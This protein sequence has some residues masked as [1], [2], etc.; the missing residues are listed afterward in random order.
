MK[1]T[2]NFYLSEWAVSDLFPDLAKE[3]TFTD[4][5]EIRAMLSAKN[6][7]STRDFANMIMA[8]EGYT[9]EFKI[10]RGKSIP[11]L[12]KALR[13][14]GYKVSKTS[15][16]LDCEATDFI[17]IIKSRSHIIQLSKAKM[18]SL[19]WKIFNYLIAHD[20]YWQLII[21]EDK[22]N[23]IEFIHH[24]I[25]PYNHLVFNTKLKKAMFRQNGKYEIIKG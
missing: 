25:E 23:N 19:Y 20:R 1:L 24:S 10:T 4:A 5:D 3:I 2:P 18:N 11:K 22:D 14:A 15:Q 12:E 6:L 7:Q 9:V 21:Y 8:R 16:H 13:G 17:L